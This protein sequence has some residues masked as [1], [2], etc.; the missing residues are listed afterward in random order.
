MHADVTTQ[1]VNCVRGGAAVKND[2]PQHCQRGHRRQARVNRGNSNAASDLNRDSQMCMAAKNRAKE[3][4]EKDV[5]ANCKQYIVLDRA[6]AAD[7]FPNQ[8]NCPQ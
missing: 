8:N 5:G 3:F 4:V 6:C 1:A 2:A 7:N